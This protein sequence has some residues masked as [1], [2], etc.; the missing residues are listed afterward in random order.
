M[1]IFRNTEKQGDDSNRNPAHAESC[2]TWVW[3]KVRE[4]HTHGWTCQF[5]YPYGGFPNW[6]VPP[7]IIHL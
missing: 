2:C 4:P 6:K 7:V 5:Q 3:V 1:V